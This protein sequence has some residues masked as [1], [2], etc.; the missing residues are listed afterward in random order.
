MKVVYNSQTGLWETH[1][2]DVN[3]EGL[4]NAA[5]TP[6]IRDELKTKYGW[7]S[8]SEFYGLSE[9][10]R[11]AAQGKN[12]N[13]VLDL[14]D[15]EFGEADSDPKNY[16][17]VNSL[18]NWCYVKILQDAGTVKSQT[19]FG[20]AWDLT[21][22]FAKSVWD[23]V[24]STVMEFVETIKNFDWK[25]PLTYITAPWQF[26]WAWTKTSL[27]VIYGLDLV[28]YGAF[29]VFCGGI[30]YGATHTLPTFA[31]FSE[32]GID[33]EERPDNGNPY[34]Y[35]CAVTCVWDGYR[36]RWVSLKK[37][38][39]YWKTFLYDNYIQLCLTEVR[40]S[41]SG[42]GCDL[43]KDG[44]TAVIGGTVMKWQDQVRQWAAA[45][46]IGV[47]ETFTYETPNENIIGYIVNA[48]EN[49][50]AGKYKDGEE[51]NEYNITVDTAWDKCLLDV[52]RAMSY[53]RGLFELTREDMRLKF[54]E[55]TGIDPISFG[56]IY[57]QGPC[58]KHVRWVG[59]NFD[60]ES[61]SQWTVHEIWGLYVPLYQDDCRMKYLD[62]S[63]AQTL[64]RANEYQEYLFRDTE[65]V[66]TSWQGT[67]VIS[68][69]SD[70]RMWLALWLRWTGIGYGDVDKGVLAHET[71][72]QQ[73]W[74]NA[75]EM[76]QTQILSEMFK[77][78]DD[79]GYNEWCINSNYG[80]EYKYFTVNEEVP[81]VIGNKYQSHL[82]NTK[83]DILT[84]EFDDKV[85]ATIELSIQTPTIE[86]SKND[87]ISTVEK[88]K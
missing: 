21:K 66:E 78:H 84:S 72:F 76:M 8:P 63:T 79:Y 81:S 49:Y 48:F 55:E 86:R 45:M 58:E 3:T 29:W 40:M 30:I 61:W 36:K 31:E 59:N 12:L 50:K 62:N 73:Q 34:P 2:D 57:N 74:Q 43:L 80:T 87:L 33:D 68:R 47:D 18:A 4:G 19:R 35:I 56:E 77:R 65:T 88:W 23:Y 22:S 83:T 41:F 27:T 15:N 52:A 85:T 82:I 32:S 39:Q 70:G 28:S 54:M 46:G 25:H 37:L 51:T 67:P 64:I 11:R 10:Q 42:P 5:K 53:S 6:S 24:S 1:L 16:F 69:F 20:Y 7:M 38:V 75:D 26:L 60:R 13:I 14:T 17:W 44:G 71:K 9:E